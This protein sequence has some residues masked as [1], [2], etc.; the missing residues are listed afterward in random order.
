MTVST[1]SGDERGEHGPGLWEPAG[2]LPP[3]GQAAGRPWGLWRRQVR[4]IVRLELGKV[5]FSRWALIGW[6]LALLPVLLVAAR[7]AIGLL[8]ER[9]AAAGTVSE[10]AYAMVFQTL[11]LRL[12]VFFGCLAIFLNLF[13]GEMHQRTLHY[14]LLAPVRREV[15]AGGKFLGGWLGA[16]LLFGGATL[17]TRLLLLAPPASAD[18][19]GWGGGPWLGL[20][21][22]YV[23]VALLACLSYGAV[24]LLIGL[25]PINPIVPAILLF[26]WESANLVLPAVLKPIS[27]FYYLEALCPVPLDLGPIAVLSTPPPRPLAL[28]GTLG[29]TALLLGVAMRRARGLEI[30]YGED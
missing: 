1:L 12:S 10:A 5:L 17:L 11:I 7:I 21:I 29:L 25:L 30:D 13:R 2:H 20:T 19:L 15:L 8:L 26:A 22:A 27:V 18:A 14:C 16:A 4:G 3:A 9:G 28:A 6:G 24:F 23:G